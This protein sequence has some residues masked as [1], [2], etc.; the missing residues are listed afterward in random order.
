MRLPE[1]VNA[2]SALSLARTIRSGALAAAVLA[3]LC[4]GPAVAP[5]FAQSAVRVLVNDEPITSF[6]I[7][8]R[9]R[10]L[11]VFTRGKEGEKQAIEQLIDERLMV[12]EAKRR[13]MLASDAEVDEEFARRAAQSKLA[14]AQFAQALRQAGVDPQTFRDFLRANMSWNDIVRARIR[15]TEEVSDQD[16]AAAVT[17]AASAAEETTIYEYMLQQIVFVVPAKAG[18][19]EK[20]RQRQRA[21]AFRSGFQGCDNSLAQAAGMTGVV[22]KPAVRR[23]ETQMNSKVREV[24]AAL[25]VGGITEPQDAEE[26]IQLVAVCEKR[27]VAGKSQATEEARSEIAS[28]RGQLMARR[29]IR[30]LRSDAV[31][32]Y[33]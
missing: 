31:I 20:N 10:M 27:E 24:M 17:S 11:A 19:G 15:A 3:P 33:K 2:M 9:A 13:S 5:A 28:K 14:P 16:V 7:Q 21:A 25:P 30:D 23:E 18:D 4:L 32:E 29:Y 22:V 8:N 1:E 6:D 12:Q 26:G